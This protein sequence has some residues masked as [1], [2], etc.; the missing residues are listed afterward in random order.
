MME[1]VDGIGLL[2][3]KYETVVGVVW[4]TWVPGKL[5]TECTPRYRQD[6]K[7]YED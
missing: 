3:R 7:H 6:T 2:K 5:Q 4:Q 1:E